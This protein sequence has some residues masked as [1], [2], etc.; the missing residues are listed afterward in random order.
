MKKFIVLLLIFNNASYTAVSLNQHGLG[1]MLIL[2]YY[3]VNNELNT[4]VSITNTS[5]TTS[6]AI[7]VIFKEGQTGYSV[8]GT[9]VYL[10]PN[11][12][13]T[14]VM[15]K[16]GQDAL[17]LSDD[18][19]CAPNFTG[20]M[21]LSAESNDPI[22]D[23]SDVNLFE[24]HIEIYEMG[25]FDPSIGFGNDITFTD[26]LPND[27]AQ[28]TSNWQSGGVWQGNDTS[29]EL[30][31]PMGDLSASV[32]LIDVSNGI[33]YSYDATAVTGFSTGDTTVH[34]APDDL[35]RPALT[36]ANNIS[37]VM[38]QGEPVL[39]TWPT[40]F[41]AISAILMKSKL[42]IE[43][44][45]EISINGQT[46]VILSFPTKFHHLQNDL[47]IEPFV[48]ISESNSLEDCELFQSEIFDR[49]S[50]IAYFVPGDVSPRPSF[51]CGTTSV[52]KIRGSGST[53]VAILEALNNWQSVIEDNAGLYKI[54]FTQ[55][56]ERGQNED[57]TNSVYHGL[58]V[59]GLYLTRYTNANA[60]PGLLA[61]YGAAF[62]TKNQVTNPVI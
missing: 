15:S 32:N 42:A 56:T 44:S 21:K 19:S 38:Y 7:K 11:D 9:N 33:N 18:L 40:G 26:G 36:D 50:A 28:I 25:S 58:P 23:S 17:V 14:F 6:K 2:P 48:G 35:Q 5:S 3:T 13:W 45:S 16:S 24:G 57:N 37:M 53:Y 10:A 43:Y 47:R 54:E 49:D 61:Q 1:D 39:T 20:S 60:Q 62:I 29:I 22:P 8:G 51:L 12:M 46:E 31:P 52:V 59:V 4:L 34:S 27:C 30:L 41:E 55:K